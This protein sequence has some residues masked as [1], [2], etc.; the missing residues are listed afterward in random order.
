MLDDRI[1]RELITD[2]L[3]TRDKLCMLTSRAN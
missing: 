1:I 2:E 3:T